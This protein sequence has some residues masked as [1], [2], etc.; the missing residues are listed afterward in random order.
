MRRV[1]SVILGMACCLALATCALGQGNPRG[2]ASLSIGSGTVSVE[3]GRPSLHGGTVE[4]RL[5]QLPAGGFWRLGADKSTT[6]STSVD[7][8]FGGVSVPKGDYSIWVQKE[9]DS[10]YKLAFNK[11]H[12]QWGAGAGAH[13]P[14]QDLASV[15]LKQEK[16]KPAE[17][18]TISLE[19]EN[20]GGQISIHWGDMELT[21][22][23]MAK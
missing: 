12:G 17:M 8:D 23:F 11:R 4:D 13:D 16:G 7:L 1:S 14:A 6:F 18:V 19:K 2:K 5:G 20:G 3:Y 15:P 22:P 10:S 21:A 9:S